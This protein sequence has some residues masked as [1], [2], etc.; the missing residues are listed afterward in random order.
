LESLQQFTQL[1]R[2]E[3]PQGAFIDTTGLNIPSPYPLQALPPNLEYLC[4]CDP[5][6]AIV[7]WLSGILDDRDQLRNLKWVLLD[8][9]N[10]PSKHLSDYWEAVGEAGSRLFEAGIDIRYNN[11]HPSC[12]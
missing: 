12:R 8:F 9:G 4:V 11:A 3:I 5:T 2:L 7:D 6:P 1:N 10:D